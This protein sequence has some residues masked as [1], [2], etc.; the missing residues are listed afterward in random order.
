MQICLRKFTFLPGISILTTLR[1]PSGAICVRIY[2]FA[3]SRQPSL[4][5]DCL[6]D[7]NQFMHALS[8]AYHKNRPFIN[9]E[10]IQV[11]CQPPKVV[12]SMKTEY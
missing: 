11:A 4:S 6:M 3:P 10:N 12:V 1:L 5:A 7:K 2:T 8:S 9:H